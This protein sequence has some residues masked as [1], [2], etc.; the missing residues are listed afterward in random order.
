MARVIYKPLIDDPVNP[1]HNPQAGELFMTAD[2]EPYMKNPSTN[3]IQEFASLSPSAQANVDFHT[4]RERARADYLASGFKNTGR[5]RSNNAGMANI[6]A[7][8]IWTV[9]S[10][11]GAK[12][13]NQMY[14]G[15]HPSIEHE[16]NS[17]SFYPVAVVDGI[18]IHMNAG[19]HQL[20]NVALPKAPD[21][22][23]YNTEVRRFTSLSD[24]V[25]AG[26]TTL[27]KSVLQRRDFVFLEV[28]AERIDQKGVVYPNGNVHYR[29]NVYK[30]IPLSN[31]NVSALY[32]AH[33]KWQETDPDHQPV[34]GY[35]AVWAA[36][37][38]KEKKKFLNDPKN[39]IYFDA[40]EGAYI[41]Y[42]YRI[43][44]E[45]GL[46]S[47]W[48]HVLPGRNQSK[49]A[50]YGVYEA[51]VANINNDLFVVPKGSRV[52]NF[53]MLNLNTI[54][55]SSG[56][57]H[58][59]FMSVTNGNLPQ[60]I[61]EKHAADSNLYIARNY[62]TGD[63]PSSETT[64]SEILMIPVGFIQR[65]N[66]GAFHI[67]YNFY[68]T[69]GVG[70]STNP[71]VPNAW[72]MPNARKPSTTAECFDVSK[73]RTT[74]AT[75][76]S[77][78]GGPSKAANTG[79]YKYHDEI[80]YGQYEDLRLFINGV[81]K[82]EI[83][84]NL[85]G[86]LSVPVV[87]DYSIGEPGRLSDDDIP[88]FSGI[89]SPRRTEPLYSNDNSASLPT[90]EG[91]FSLALSSNKD[92][93]SFLTTALPKWANRTI[94]AF[95]IN[96]KRYQV[97][98][99]S[100]NRYYLN[101]N[102]SFD[103][104]VYHAK[105]NMTDGSA[106]GSYIEF[107]AIDIAV[108]FEDKY[109]GKF[110]VVPC[111]EIVARTD[112]LIQQFPSGV[113]AT[114]AN[115][116]PVGNNFGISTTQVGLVFSRKV[117]TNGEAYH[118]V[119]TKENYA[120][121]ISWQLGDVVAAAGY[122]IRNNGFQSL[123]IEPNMIKIFGYDTW[124]ARFDDLNRD[125]EMGEIRDSVFISYSLPVVQ[126][127]QDITGY[128]QKMGVGGDNLIEI[129]LVYKTHSA[130]PK[131]AFVPKYDPYS[132]K[133]VRFLVGIHEKDGLLYAVI[134]G[135][136]GNGGDETGMLPLSNLRWMISKKP[137]GVAKRTPNYSSRVMPTLIGTALQP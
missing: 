35:S 24:A 3:E 48:A 133:R 60:D 112:I 42:R 98:S 1:T 54:V 14:F 91:T 46:G 109:D 4:N 104:G 136:Y 39:N 15:V 21:G 16:G 128:F 72:Y 82:A 26:G 121:A 67:A 12:D 106:D 134:L 119:L 94:T 19:D 75:S 52:E 33:G 56:S 62:E 130:T 11:S 53:D 124:A 103:T 37:T 90:F 69:A 108:E 44:V 66:T 18:H 10:K 77:W 38:T 116:E 6:L 28:W 40:A 17:P 47:N 31:L 111:Y 123:S 129:P 78:I 102:V 99:V 107:F 23:D 81:G 68:G 63:A 100:G 29:S 25:V 5:H 65:F 83:T 80:T 120:T 89:Q 9:S 92:S 97:E 115:F 132:S 22:L 49:Y 43:R 55:G 50:A 95:V 71:N 122:N 135:D 79:T 59:V 32:S 87:Y 126:I 101:S 74:D 51:G 36:L 61:L 93:I 27:S 105:G 73:G 58:D 41:Q 88:V 125:I 57:N 76:G 118:T 113:Y 45:K 117:V 13:P 34:A 64:F 137:V 86:A 2:C 30:G 96:N 20:L 8:G 114:C 131:V 85:L 84:D 7:D 127:A 110:R 70:D